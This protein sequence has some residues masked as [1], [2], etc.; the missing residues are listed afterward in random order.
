MVPI[1][2]LLWCV[3]SRDWSFFRNIRSI[4]GRDAFR[5][6]SILSMNRWLGKKGSHWWKQ[7]INR[8]THFNGGP[9]HCSAFHPG[10][11][12]LALRQ[13]LQ[14]SGLHHQNMHETAQ[15]TKNTYS[16][17]MHMSIPQGWCF[18]VLSLDISQQHFLVTFVTFK[19]CAFN[20]SSSGK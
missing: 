9:P 3:Y 18:V 16:L 20:R 10:C 7:M 14:S 6:F 13:I 12:S 15:C 5:F 19:E 8:K 2:L 4:Q 1:S 17:M 11:S